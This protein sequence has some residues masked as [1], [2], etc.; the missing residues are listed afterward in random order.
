MKR[1]L[2]PLLLLKKDFISIVLYYGAKL[3]I[4]RDIFFSPSYLRE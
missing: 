4:L 3:E 1:E 2:E